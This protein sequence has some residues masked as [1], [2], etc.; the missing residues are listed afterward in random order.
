MLSKNS[1][2]CLALACPAS[3]W[4]KGSI[5]L[6]IAVAGSGRRATLT[7]HE[8]DACNS[9]RQRL[10]RLQ[11]PQGQRLQVLNNSCEMELIP[12]AG[13]ASQPQPLEVMMRLQMCKSHLDALSFVA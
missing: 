9:R 5:G 12:G 1:S 6:G 11:Q 10:G 13:Q 2:F 7:Q 4:A 3:T 8:L